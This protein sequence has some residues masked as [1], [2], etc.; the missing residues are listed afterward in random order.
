MWFFIPL[1]R[2]NRNNPSVPKL[3]GYSLVI[4]DYSYRFLT[5][6]GYLSVGLA[7]LQNETV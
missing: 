2:P 6:L 1:L 5:Y 3:I 7:H 4:R